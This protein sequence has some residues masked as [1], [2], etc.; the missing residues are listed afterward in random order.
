M[1]N[2]KFIISN[3]RSWNGDNEIDL[4]KI[5]L[6]LGA[7]S[8]GKSSIIHALALLKQSKTGHR[9]IPKGDHID[10]GRI[11]DQVNASVKSL[12]GRILS[13]LIGFGL[14][15][16]ISTG[17]ILEIGRV[18]RFGS[19]RRVGSDNVNWPAERG[20]YADTLSAE[21]D[22]ITYIE[23]YDDLGRMVNISLHATNFQIAAIQASYRGKTARFSFDFTDE[24]EFWSLIVN[25]N[26][27]KKE[28]DKD[29]FDEAEIEK[30]RYLNLLHK[31]RNE[32]KS[33]R[34]K[35]R[36]AQLSAN[37]KTLQ[38]LQHLYDEAQNRSH[39][40]ATR[41]R[42]LERETRNTKI[43]GRTK[44]QKCK[45]LSEMLSVQFSTSMELCEKTDILSVF[46]RSLT[47]GTGL[48]GPF[49][50][51][52]SAQEAT[53]KTIDALE[54]IASN[55][56][57][58]LISPFT[59]FYWAKTKF[60]H[61][62][63]TVE[64]IGP[65]RE[66]PDRIT[67]VNPND[68]SSSVGVKGENVMSIIHQIPKKQIKELNDWFKILEIPYSVDRKFTRRFNISQLILKDRN[69]TEVALADVGYGIGQVL[70]VVLTSMLRSNTIIAVEQPELHLHPKLQA[71]LADLFIKSAN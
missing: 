21:L 4:N 19:T 12:K 66:R 70:P 50:L 48:H 55:C 65:H 30:E 51:G 6:L 45:N 34:K 68:Q 36:E 67:F 62:I 26:S 49:D 63:S 3:F 60:N 38:K 28:I 71:N 11:E 24:Y 53:R 22:E 40:Y 31:K 47:T 59:L 23:K 29:Q 14:R 17:N 39:F 69:G 58:F 42:K 61:M 32:I 64:R 13:D 20:E 16:Q 9:L 43:P 41:L 18:G 57:H 54:L 8:S 35:I 10:L 15:S 2:N 7:N 46:I 33:I 52:R 27:S 5:N 44:K 37:T 25:F 56:D 1:K